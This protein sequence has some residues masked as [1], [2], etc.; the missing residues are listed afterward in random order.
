MTTSKSPVDTLISHFD[1]ALKTVS[2][3]VG[4]TRR[5]S[6]ARELAE[7]E[8][9]AD[10]RQH[11]ARLMRVNHCGE[12]CAQALYHGQS[13]TAKSSRT[14]SAMKAAADEET[15]HLSWCETRIN[16]LDSH[17][18][19]LN[20]LWYGT[21]FVMGAIAGLLGDKINLGFV[22]ATEEEVCRHLD[23]HLEKLPWG[24]EKSRSV[25]TQMREDEA[26]HATHAIE[27][28]GAKFPRPVKLAMRGVSNLMTRTTYWI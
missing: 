22:A 24:D 25:L 27:F 15:D 23:D 21:S 11:S 20:P 1:A 26:R 14:A 3:T 13:L 16:E 17:V 7:P 6:P 4:T 18:S 12:V 10:E 19:Y 8:L 5:H 9:T 2:G 28:G